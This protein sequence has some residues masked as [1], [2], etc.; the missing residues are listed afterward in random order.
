MKKLRILDESLRMGQQALWATRM[1]TSWMLPIAQ[2]MDAA[3]FYQVAAMAPVSFETAAMYLYEN[4]WERLRLLRRHMPHTQFDF[5]VRS[6][7]VVGWFPKS[8]DVVEL[9]LK[10][11]YDTGVH[12][13]KVFD[14]LNDYRNVAYHIEVGKRIGFH[15]KALLNFAVSPVHTD[16]YC[17][18]K[19]RQLANLGVD[20][21]VIAD[22]CGAMLPERART[23][24]GRVRAELPR[25]ELHFSTH[26]NSGVS[27]PCYR[28]A[29]RQ[30]I[31]V[32]WGASTP[33]A[34]GHSFPPHQ[35]IVQLAREEDRAIDLDERC[36]AEMDDW[37]AWAAY[38][39]K[40]PT[41]EPEEFDPVEYE[42][43]IRHQIPGGMMSNLESQLAGVGM[44]HRLPEV[45]EEAAR[46]R[47]ELGYPVMVTPFS[48]FV[49][50]QATLNVVTGERY[51]SCPREM[52][53]YCRGYYGQSPGPIDPNVLDRVVGD[54]PMIDPTA[55]YEDRMVDKARAERPGLSD[56]ELLTSMFLNPT[57][58]EAF[59]RNRKPIEWDPDARMPLVALLKELG[60]RPRLRRVD[61]RSGGLRMTLSRE[62]G[63]LGAA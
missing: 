44:A 4:P 18:A 57:A 58:L 56:E 16:D 8:N 3:G 20:A 25:T 36:L 10:T 28:E 34:N 33:L 17:V 63:A 15:V 49:G 47:A 38:K 27:T 30:G 11:L 7:N 42:R 61:V 32:L 45:L 24:I 55:Y 6:R 48:Q 21:I 51:S 41:H 40:R 37:F 60:N 2:V 19:A 5:L 29:I 9:F 23:L 54:Q 59:N 1:K 35:T 14:G 31:D 62:S 26:P 39:E 46:V 13:I 50:V 53:L 12:G 43:T 22:A 52:V